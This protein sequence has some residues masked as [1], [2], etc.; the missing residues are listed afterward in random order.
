M[1]VSCYIKT[2]RVYVG[3]LLRMRDGRRTRSRMRGRD[4]IGALVNHCALFVYAVAGKLESVAE[5][6]SV[7]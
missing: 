2:Y 6:I 5:I 7:T 1:R 4:Q 3:M